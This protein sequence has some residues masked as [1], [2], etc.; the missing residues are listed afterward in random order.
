[1]RALFLTLPLVTHCLSC[2]G[3]TSN[4]PVSPANGS[5]LTGNVPTAPELGSLDSLLPLAGPDSQLVAADVAAERRQAADSAAD[6]AVLEELADAR[7]DSAA[8]DHSGD[9]EPEAEPGGA[10]GEAVTWDIDVA[11]YNHHNRVQYYLDFFR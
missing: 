6:E 7:P 1:M 3:H 10:N 8:D 9:D 5:P 11:T 4:R 2:A